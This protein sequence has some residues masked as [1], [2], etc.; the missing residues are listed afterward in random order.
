MNRKISS[1]LRRKYGC[2]A[3]HTLT[4]THAFMEKA[5]YPGKVLLFF[6]AGNLAQFFFVSQIK[7]NIQA[8]F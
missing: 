4:I 1:N 3:I 8:M 7:S 2:L 5:G 6:L